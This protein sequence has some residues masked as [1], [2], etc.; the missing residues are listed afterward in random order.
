VHRD[1]AKAGT[2]ASLIPLAV[3]GR[4]PTSPA[5]TSA[6]R[7]LPHVVG[8][9]A[10]PSATLFEVAAAAEVFG[11]HS[12]LMDVRAGTRGRYALRVCGLE[13]G[14]VRLTR[15]FTVEATH[16]LDALADADTLLVPA[17]EPPQ[18][19]PRAV[20]QALLRAH[21]RGARI[22]AIRSGAFLL[23]AA[24]LLDGRRATTHWTHSDELRRR[25]PDIHVDPTRLFVHDG[26]VATAAG[27]A[28]TV[29]LCVELIRLDHGTAVANA[30]A[31]QFLTAPHRAADG[32]QL[33]EAPLPQIDDDLTQLLNWALARLD[34]P[35]TLA[36]LAR[37]ANLSQRTLAR[38]FHATLSTTPLQ[39]LLHQRI[40]LA[41]QL[42][43][44]TQEPIGQIAKL[45]GLGSP[46][47]LRRKFASIT[48]RSPQSYRRTFRGTAD[49][50]PV[51]EARTA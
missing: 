16:G 51:C 13:P 35:L 9:L 23:A 14:P 1:S 6:S 25:H 29:D 50:E 17:T 3:P 46:Q 34:Q 8:I 27:A 24:G 48:G 49:P 38:R 44:T 45:A 5:R 40:R 15:G 21:V 47:N 41:Q 20:L 19:P 36:D 11:V 31:R 12:S 37:Q 28:S 18:D 32:P 26:T 33:V 10:L 42:L 7:H 30:V 2:P 4:Q 43:E 22:V 39:W